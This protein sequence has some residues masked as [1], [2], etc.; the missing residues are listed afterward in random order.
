MNKEI[1]PQQYAV[2]TNIGRNKLESLM[3]GQKLK[4]V[5]MVFGD[6]NGSAVKPTIDGTTLINEIGRE[7]ITEQPESYFGAGVFMSSAMLAKYN[8]KWLREVGLIDSDGD[9]IVWACYA[10][11]L[12]SLYAEKTIIVHLPV[13]NA[14]QIEVV[15]DTTKKYVSQSEFD[16]LKNEVLSLMQVQDYTSRASEL[17]NPANVI[18]ATLPRAI[19]ATIP[20]GQLQIINDENGRPLFTPVPDIEYVLSVQTFTSA[21]GFEQT[22]TIIENVQSKQTVNMTLKRS[23]ATFDSAD[24]WS[25]MLGLPPGDLYVYG[26]VYATED[27][28]LIKDGSARYLSL[29]SAGLLGAN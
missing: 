18:Y 1:D 20:P 4:I 28:R 21:V 2:I 9:L 5:S 17:A 16:K 14:E 11:T 22:L 13:S 6:G 25:S 7:P 3:V 26:S 15:V 10:P 12:I 29:K 24:T 23:G 27:V 19:M 8:G